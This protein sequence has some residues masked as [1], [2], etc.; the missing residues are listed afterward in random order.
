HKL[1]RRP[2]DGALFP[3]QNA[4]PHIYVNPIPIDETREFAFSVY[5]AQTG[6]NFIYLGSLGQ[7]VNDTFNDL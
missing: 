4:V 3:S 2:A 7:P 5:N 6:A 1:M